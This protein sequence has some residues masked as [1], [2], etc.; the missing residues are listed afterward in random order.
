[1]VKTAMQNNPREKGHAVRCLLTVAMCLV[2]CYL[3]TGCIRLW[4]GAAYV[5]RKPGEYAERTY[6]FDTQAL[7]QKDQTPSVTNASS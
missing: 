4:G 3:L 1:M 7:M 5:S 2:L 6:G